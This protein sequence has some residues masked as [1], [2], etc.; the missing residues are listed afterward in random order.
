MYGHH[1]HE[2]V[3]EAFKRGEVEYSAVSMHFVT[4][5]YDRGPVFFDLKIKIKDDD[6]PESLGQRVN[7]AEHRWQPCITKMVVNGLVRWD[8]VNHDSLK[9]PPNYSIKNFE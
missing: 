3:M 4:E 1:V 8:G 6:T 7:Q 5:G 9:V 2:A